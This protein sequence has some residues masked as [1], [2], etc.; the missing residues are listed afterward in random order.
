MIMEKKFICISCPKGCHLVVDVDKR[1]VSGNSCKRGEAYGLSE[2]IAPVRTITSVVKINNSD[3]KMLPVKSDKPI[4]KE[5]NF[6]CMKEINKVTL[7][8]PV[9]I[10]DIVIKNVLGT[11]V[12]IVASRNADKV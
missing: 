3:I 5:L 9:K 1:I 8:A 12:N 10:G 2:A 4:K 6:M 7:D 11:D